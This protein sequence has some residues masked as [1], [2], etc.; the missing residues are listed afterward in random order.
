MENQLDVESRQ[1]TEGQQKS[2]TQ[3]AS[4]QYFVQIFN[5]DQEQWTNGKALPIQISSPIWLEC[6]SNKKF[7]RTCSVKL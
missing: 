1:H 4:Q 2:Q 6:G 5:W 7:S 3:W